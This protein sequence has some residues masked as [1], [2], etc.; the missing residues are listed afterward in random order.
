[1]GAFG[2][3]YRRM[4]LIGVGL[5]SNYSDGLRNQH[6]TLLK[7]LKELGVLKDT[8]WIC[9]LSPICGHL[10]QPRQPDEVF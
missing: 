8:F 10:G 6:P 3:P 7:E 2:G 5:I 1:M 9:P 4:G